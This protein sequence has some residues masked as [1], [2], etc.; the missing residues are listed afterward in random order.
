MVQVVHVDAFG[1]QPALDA[2]ECK[3]C[4]HI[5]SRLREEQ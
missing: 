4:K 1:D 2:Y 3:L 5:V